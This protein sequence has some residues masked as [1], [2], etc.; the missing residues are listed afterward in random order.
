MQ[1]TCSGKA[2]DTLVY[3]S[4]EEEVRYYMDMKKKARLDAAAR[5]TR[6]ERRGEARGEARGITKGETSTIRR[7]II[8]AFQLGWDPAVIADI[9][10]ASL[11]EIERIRKELA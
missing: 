6:A 11:E 1:S 3:V 9:T 5:E 4:E 2:V 7:T 10:G 8:R